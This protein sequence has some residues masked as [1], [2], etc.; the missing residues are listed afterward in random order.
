MREPRWLRPLARV[1]LIVTSAMWV[2]ASGLELA[3]SL[4]GGIPRCEVPGKGDVLCA[5]RLPLWI[6][7]LVGLLGVLAAYLAARL[8]RPRPA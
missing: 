8:T 5:T 4:V 1:Y 3:R 6:A 2:T 7:A